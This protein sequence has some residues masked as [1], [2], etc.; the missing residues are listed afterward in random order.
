L[1]LERIFLGADKSQ[2]LYHFIRSPLL[3]GLNDDN[4]NNKHQ[5]DCSIPRFS[6]NEIN[7]SRSRNTPRA[8]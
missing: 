1:Q 6:K 4:G 2:G 8:L 3:N 5:Y 7:D